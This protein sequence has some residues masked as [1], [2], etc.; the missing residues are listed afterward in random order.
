MQLD[1]ASGVNTLNIWKSMN[2]T[3]QFDVFL[4]FI[5][6]KRPYSKSMYYLTDIKLVR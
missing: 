5:K 1:T 4:D 6:D 3:Y 2:I